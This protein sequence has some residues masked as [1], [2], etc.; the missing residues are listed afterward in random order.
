MKG[1]WHYL[2]AAALS[3]LLAACGSGGD[4]GTGGAIGSAEPQA[5]FGL[6]KPAGSDSEMSQSLKRGLAQNTIDYAGG[7]PLAVEELAGLDGAPAGYGGEF[8]TTNV[9]EDG[10]DEADVA[11][12]DGEILYVL[13]HRPSG[14]NSDVSGI[15]ITQSYESSAVRLFRTDPDGVAAAQIAQINVDEAVNTDTGDTLLISGLYL[16]QPDG[17]K[18]LLTMGQNHTAVPWEVFAL[19]YYWQGGGTTIT[20]WDVADATSPELAWNLSLDGSLLTSRRI[21][22]TLLVVTRYAPTVAGLVPYATDEEQLAAN[23]RLIDN[24]PLNALLPDVR[25]DENPPRELVEPGDCYLPNP[26]YEGVSLPPASS[27][28]ITVT[29]IDLRAPDDSR[30]ICLNAFASGF[31]MSLNNLYITANGSHDSTLIH[32]V[33][34]NGV[35]P[36]YRGSGVV[37]GYIGTS[38]PAYLMSEHDGD[39]RVISSSWMGRAFPLPVVDV[40]PAVE[41][42]QQSTEDFGVHRLTVLRESP[43]GMALEAVASLPNSVRPQHIGKPGE[44]IYAARFLG[45]RA[46][47]VT[48]EVIDPLYVLDLADPEDPR[49]AGELE[50]PGFSNI[51]QPLGDSLLLGVGS[52]VTAAGPVLTLGVK[53]GLFDVS[54][55]SAPIELGNVVV[56]KRGSSSPAQH[57]YHAL[58]VHERNGVYRVAMPIDRH[59]TLPE[60]DDDQSDPAYWYSWTDSGLFKFEVEPAT[61][62]IE[63]LPPLVSEARDE[64]QF[65]PAYSAYTSRAIVHGDTVFFTQESRV[66]VEEWGF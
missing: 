38:N 24:A 5:A 23:S 53:V 21:G 32:K 65:W 16:A 55:I 49:V 25:F 33:S 56:G 51:L 3:G 27:S 44:D 50:I 14:D 43:E 29:A 15:S 58:T 11:K 13:E 2:G 37:P 42:A 10:V 48:F 60:G 1:P 46:Y 6:L 8:S 22:D 35:N 47:A 41:S 26:D 62:S 59:T 52:E 64:Q 12:Y 57:N 63:T 66:L 45:D 7:P 54:D 19:D 17:R 34:I 28:I 31:Y 36:Q 18:L 20:A 9:Q 39:L 61:G 4:S 30:S 40:L